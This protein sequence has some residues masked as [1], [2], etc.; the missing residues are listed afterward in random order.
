MGESEIRER[1]EQ[2]LR[3]TASRLREQGG[4]AHPEKQS[5]VIPPE[6]PVGDAFD[7]IEALESR[8]QDL[9]SRERLA[10]RLDRIVEALE[11]L[12]DGSYGTCTACGGPIGSA[13]LRAIPEATMCVGCQEGLEPGRAAGPRSARAFYSA[14]RGS[15]DGLD[16]D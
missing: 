4:L 13:R 6:G 16:E 11:H 8:E 1:L 10:G 12:R 3:V 14:T 5:E 9:A 2:E 15:S 7:R